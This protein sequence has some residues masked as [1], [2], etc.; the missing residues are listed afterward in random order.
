VRIEDRW[1]GGEERGK[2][3]NKKEILC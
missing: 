2:D 3:K 1:G